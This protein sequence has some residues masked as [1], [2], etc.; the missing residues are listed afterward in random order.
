MAAITTAAN[1]NWSA[2]GT[3][4]GG[5][6]P[7]NGDTVIY[8]HNLTVDVPVTVGHSP[9]NSDAVR[10]LA[11]GTANKKLTV[12]APLTIR[13][14]LSL[15]GNTTKTTVL[16]V[17]GNGAGIEFDASASASPSTTKYRLITQDANNGYTVCH[18]N[19]TATDRVFLRSNAGGGNAYLTRAGATVGGWFKANY[20]DF[21][22]IGDASN[23]F[24]DYYLGNNAGAEFIL[25]HCVGDACGIPTSATAVVAGGEITVTDTTWKNTA[26]AS[27][28]MVFPTFTNS[29]T[30]VVTGNCFDRQVDFGQGAWTVEDNLFYEGYVATAGT[31]WASSARNIVRR[32]TQPGLNIYCSPIDELWYKAGAI[33]NAHHLV[34]GITAS[35][36]L[37]GVIFATENA[38]G[39][40]DAAQP[41]SPSAARLYQNVRCILLPDETSGVQSGKLQGAGGNANV[42]IENWH[43]TYISTAA[44]ETGTGYGETYA[45]HDGIVKSKS[46]LAWSPSAGG[47][48]IGIRQA[49]SVQMSD[50]TTWDYNAGWNLRSGTDGAG[51]N[52]IS[53]GV[54]FSSG[55]PGAND[56]VLSGD[57]FYDRTRNVATWDASLGG[58][59]TAAHAFA[60]IAKKNDPSGYNSAYNY[61][62]LLAYIQEGFEVVD[63]SIKDNGHDGV[64]RG[65][66]P[67]RATG[68]SGTA[69]SST[70][71]LASAATGT[72]S[73]GGTVTSAVGGLRSQAAGTLTAIGTA[74]SATGALSSL[75]N[76]V[77]GIVGAVTSLLAAL[78]S[79]ATGTTG[80]PPAST[81]AGWVVVA[82]G[83]YQWKIIIRDLT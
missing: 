40:G 72:Q 39:V 61:P 34:Y 81:T 63:V 12:N 23:P 58:P 3:W 69:A 18:F 21:G 10:A 14:D 53:A 54:I 73:A 41:G 49:G 50:A 27:K 66:R 22:R 8:N 29:G 4:T 13:G 46:C 68:V 1:G 44:G 59:G 83:G 52:S 51:Y 42:S 47:A 79:R 78:Q 45:G 38:N 30:R 37:D 74:A 2:T 65:A 71:G 62:A 56:V 31:M 17:Q 67:Y 26:H 5:V 75:A 76:A 77:G 28:A 7:G 9:G 80:A 16:L 33:N 11:C 24:Y 19:G 36:T 15:K 20:C 32:S 70:G 82:R 25:Q 48:S 55:A 6:V 43:C 60:E 64:T 57:P 35:L